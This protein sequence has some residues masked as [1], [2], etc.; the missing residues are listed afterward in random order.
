MDKY[1]M[2]GEALK[3]GENFDCESKMLKVSNK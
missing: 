1:K 2:G 3:H